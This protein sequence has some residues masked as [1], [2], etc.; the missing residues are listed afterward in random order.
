MP[1]SKSEKQKTCKH[2]YK[3]V[4]SNYDFDGE[5]YECKKCGHRYRLYYDDMR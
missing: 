5:S 1:S 2:D 3:E 4:S